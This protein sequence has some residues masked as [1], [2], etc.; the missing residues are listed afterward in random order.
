MTRLKC[1]MRKV[2]LLGFLSYFFSFSAQTISSSRWSDLFSYNNVLCIREDEGKLIA[3]TENGIFY[4]TPSTGEITKLS[5]ANGLHEVKISAFDYNPDTNTGLVGYTNGTMDVI[6]DDEITYVVDIPLSTGY[7]GSKSINHIY[8]NGNQAVI[9]VDYGVS[10]FNLEKKEFGDTAYFLSGGVY[11]PSKEAVIV[12][13]KVYALT[14][15][16]IKSHDIDVT[17]PIY[18]GWETEN[19]ENFNEIDAKNGTIAFGNS[20]AV[21]Y[22]NMSSVSSISK[23]FSNVQDVTVTSGNIIV[24]DL[25]GVYVY[26]TDGS[27]VDEYASQK[28]LNT[29]WY[30]NDKIY[31]GSQ[32]S[33]ILDEDSSIY[34][35][36]GPYTNQSY[37]MTLGSKGR[38]YISTGDRTSRYNTPNPDSR[39]LGFYFYDGKEWIYPSYFLINTSF[40]L[41]NILDVTPNPSD[42]TEVWFANYQGYNVST[43]G[44]YKMK[45]DESSKDFVDQPEFYS[46]NIDDKTRMVGLVFDDSNNLYATGSYFEVGSI[47]KTTVYKYE[48]S[49]NNIFKKYLGTSKAA[50]KPLYKDGFLWIPTPRTNTFIAA[51]I[52]NASSVSD[53]TAYELSSSNNL[54]ESAEGSLSVA[55]D[56]YGDA[57]IGTDH[58]LR[59]LSNAVSTITSDPTLEEIVIEENGV[60]EELFRDTAILQIAVDSGNQKWVSTEGGGIFYLSSDGQTTIQHFTSENSPLPNNSA[61]DIQIDDSTG[62]IYFVTS[63]GIVA[64]QGDVSDV[65]ENFGDVLVY[66]NPVVY[67]NYKGT[68]KIKGLAQTTNIRITDAAGNLVHQAVAKGGYYEWDLTSRGKRVASGIY[69]VLM[70]NADGTDTATAKIAVVN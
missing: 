58:G 16:G 29:A 42:D 50:Q 15:S 66:P 65:T 38:M 31:S 34:K 37:K 51:D 55:I 26:S 25:N 41:F 63:D 20:T 64:Y 19:S 6:T 61:T 39:N 13:D 10:I 7:T 44:I 57:W 21:Y 56:N 17:F 46:T 53:V 2:F 1:N 70:T 27:P 52:S 23:T 47:Q 68:V 40:Y 62:K 49:S 33:G 24:T 30:Y 69:F 59:V 28:D 4:Y 14:S 11:V 12:E 3:A 36:D 9:S 67:A 5:K 35:P 54:P 8:I 48:R 18:S 22:G 45:Y 32:F 60:A 43:N